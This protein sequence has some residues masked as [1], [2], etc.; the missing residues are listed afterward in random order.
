MHG[1]TIKKNLPKRV[2]QRVHF[3][4]FSLKFLPIKRFYVRIP[5][6]YKLK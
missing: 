5:N 2:L 4:T 3:N 6:S 1:A